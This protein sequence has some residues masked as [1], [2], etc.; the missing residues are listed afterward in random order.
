LKIT[1]LWLAERK[2]LF[3]KIE[4]KAPVTIFFKHPGKEN[5]MRKTLLLLTTAAL[6]AIPA[7]AGPAVARDR[8][9]RA[10]LSAGQI[11]DRADARTAQ[12]KVGLR[13]TPEQE[14]N[15][16]GFET[17]MRDMGKK[18]AD[19]QIA[20]REERAQRNGPVDAI[21]QMRKKADAQMERAGD[22]KK[23]ADAAQPLYASL[24]ERQKRRFAEDLFRVDRDRAAN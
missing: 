14:K 13:L 18:R 9:D 12:M 15:W 21:E 20:L 10:Q 8:S 11:A 2:T 3:L 19:R 16:S 7:L 22:W 23:L 17:A 5:V 1:E 24:D 6:I 4:S